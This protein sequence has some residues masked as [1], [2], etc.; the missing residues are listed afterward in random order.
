MIMA[1]ANK[2]IEDKACEKAKTTAW[3]FAKEMR[4]NGFTEHEA[5]LTT[6]E[7]KRIVEDI[8]NN[9]IYTKKFA[10]NLSLE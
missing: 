2:E 4:D 1:Y 10:E 7:L 5:Y 6:V 8:C 3:K 9:S